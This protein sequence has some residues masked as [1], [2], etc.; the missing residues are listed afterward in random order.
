M[1]S[2]RLILSAALLW[3][4]LGGERGAPPVGAQ[5]TVETGG[6]RLSVNPEVFARRIAE[7]VAEL[8][9][10]PFKTEPAVKHQSIEDFENYL[11]AELRR[12]LPE[13]RRRYF[14]RIVAK[15]GLYR[16][17]EITDME[18]MIKAVMKS[19]A[20]AYY[21]P[22][23]QAFYVVMSDLPE[24]MMG[25]VYAHE[26]YHALQ[27]Q[28][29]DLQAYLLDQMEGAL[30]D[31]ELMARQAVVEGEA[32]YV[33]TLYTTRRLLGS[34][35][36]RQ[37]LTLAIN[38]QTQ[39]DTEMLRRMLKEE[40]VLGPL[41][42]QLEDAV[43]AMDEIPPFVLETLLGAYLKGMAFVHNVQG[44]G[45]SEVEALYTTRPPASSE[46]I[47]YP[48]KWI[49]GEVPYRLAWPAF[50]GVEPLTD[51]EELD[52]NTLGEI[53]WRIIFA[54]HGLASEGRAAAAGWDGD[55][56]AV[57]KRRDSDDLLLLLYTCWDTDADAQ[58]FAAA[59]DRLLAVKYAAVP[60]PTRLVR[61]GSDVLV[62]E[63]G[64]ADDQPAL[65]DFL[66]AVTK[67]KPARP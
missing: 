27:D 5:V 55:L 15:L 57:L 47:L 9:G 36:D 56:Y 49:A 17:P 6:A 34:V 20:A 67:T 2:H 41:S 3:A 7:E 66:A 61:R 28:Y 37:M 19:Q 63:G 43:K 52:V 59:Y 26:L 33:M 14:G 12:Q 64:D 16:G 8:R 50:E 51:F 10:L 53:Q 31:D 38:M 58:E 32:T 30:N 21:D 62:I 1:K 24:V 65:L 23:T 29:F 40:A 39:V 46:Q 4:G 25:A 18:A 54:E 11:E 22:A 42:G 13:K 45:W 44:R 35:P 60:E 48:E